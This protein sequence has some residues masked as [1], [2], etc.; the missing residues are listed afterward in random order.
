MRFRSKLPDRALEELCA[1]RDAYSPQIFGVTDNIL[2][3][4][5][6]ENFLPRLAEVDRQFQLFYEVKAN[7]SI[8]HLRTLK[9]AGVHLSLSRLNHW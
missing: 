9:K 5:Y 6:F 1:L 2:D 8:K 3:M 4:K 7:L